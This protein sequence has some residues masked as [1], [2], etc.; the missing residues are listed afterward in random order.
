[1]KQQSMTVRLKLSAAD[2]AWLDKLVV[3]RGYRTRAAV[4]ASLVHTIADDDR[5]LRAPA[6]GQ[7]RVGDRGGR[8]T[9]SPARRSHHGG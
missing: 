6:H 3:D 1:M 7:R 8:N 5:G 4:L 9:R 2:A